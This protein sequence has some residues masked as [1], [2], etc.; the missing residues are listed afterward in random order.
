MVSKQTLWDLM[1]AMDGDQVAVASPRGAWTRR[2]LLA[3][4]ERLAGELDRGCRGE[5]PVV[6]A[7]ADIASTAI[8][9]LAGDLAGLLVIHADPAMPQPPGGLLVREAAGNGRPAVQLGRALTLMTEPADEPPALTGVPV[10]AQAFLTS[11]S[12]GAPSAAVRAPAA[13]L[14]DARRVAT[15]LGYGPG[16]QVVASAPAFHLYG[17]TYALVAPLTS[18]AAV[19]HCGG[20]TLPSQLGRA[21]TSS[22]A[23]VII[24][25]PYQYRLLAQTAPEHAPGFGPVRIAVSAGAPLRPQDIRTLLARYEFALFNC[26]G[27]SEA[28]AVTLGPVTGTEAP[29]D[30]GRPLPGVT[31]EVDGS[32]ELLLRGDGLAAGH[33]LAGGLVPL[34]RSGGAYRT[35]D[36]ADLADGRIVLRG[37]AAAQINVGGKKVN[38][39]EVER[40]I[41]EHP[42]VRDVQVVAE[43]DPARGEVPV[44]RVVATGQVTA[45]TLLNWCRERLAPF[46]LPRRF[47]FRAELARS[48][49]GK[50]LRDPPPAPLTGG[51]RGPTVPEP[52]K[53]AMNEC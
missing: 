45:S 8:L 51:A 7:V 3:A 16:T 25:H 27:S 50:P 42:A 35:G 1:V 26:Y 41:A 43:Q 15:R 6:A 53:E 32:G 19:Y 13:I 29:G 14:A 44:A 49:T 4:A 34:P 48:V 12:T 9:T 24:A 21:A 2:D 30:A 28:G 22:G 31:A 5:L 10:Q 39:A 23:Q 46:Q 47:D 20:A 36:L 38:P 52:A 17:H 40:V 18:G 37:R 11:G 33:L